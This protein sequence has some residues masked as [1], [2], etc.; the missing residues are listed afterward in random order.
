MTV[1]QPRMTQLSWAQVK[2]LLDAHSQSLQQAYANC[3]ALKGAICGEVHEGTLTSPVIAQT[4]SLLA[5]S[6]RGRLWWLLTGHL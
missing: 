2:A 5:L 6:L 4:Q 1:K 3:D